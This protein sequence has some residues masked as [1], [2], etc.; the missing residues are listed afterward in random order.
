VSDAPR[1]S[2]DAVTVAFSAPAA[3]IHGVA[4]LG[5]SP[6]GASGLVLL[7]HGG[8]PAAVVADGGVALPEPPQG[9]SDVSAAGLDV[10]AGDD[11][12]TLSWAGDAGS[13]D[14]DLRPLGT[15]AD[16]PDGTEQPVTI[17]GAA[18]L[19]GRRHELAGMGQRTRSWAAPDWERTELAR[20]VQ[21]WLPDRAITA[22]ATRAQGKPHGSEELRA[23]VHEHRGEAPVATPVGDPRLSTTYDAEGRHRRAGLELWM[24]DDGPVHRVAGEALAG[25]TLDLGR[26]R[27]DTAFFTW[28]S[29]GQ[30]G[31]GRYDVLRRTG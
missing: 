30:E 8:E 27:L 3:D 13:L 23:L 25:T 14:L 1:L 9:W 21:V 28:R 5:V 12:W 6:E 17:E 19:A 7:F 4:R 29:A 20:T 24:T 22:Q 16:V 31:T 11:R 10:A 15:P 2:G 18:Q 26:M